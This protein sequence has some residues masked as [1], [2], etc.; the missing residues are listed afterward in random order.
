MIAPLT[1]SALTQ[2]KPNAVATQ[3]LFEKLAGGPLPR[4][5]D[6]ALAVHSRKLE[7]G[8][9]VFLEGV[10]HP[11]VYV[12]RRGLV[13]NVYQRDS[14]EAWIKS[15]NSE[16]HFFA[17]VTALR[18]GGQTSFCSVAVGSCELECIPWAVID[19]FADDDLAW[20]VVLRRALMIFAERKEQ[21]ER[22][23]LTLNAEDRYQ[24]LIAQ[25]PHLK[26]HITQKDLA[27]YI[28]VTPVGLSRILRRLRVR[29]G[30]SAQQNRT[31]YRALV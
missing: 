20:S 26:H 7:S 23:L 30:T 28:G 5:C 31:S 3:F 1:P 15:F 11:Y 12:V 19:R 8:E 9:T 17:S 16:G 25:N 18:P 27:A 14:G 2:V 10:E 24:A 21:R 13:K 22:E 29:L 4:W 6:F